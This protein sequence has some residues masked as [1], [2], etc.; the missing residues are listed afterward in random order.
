MEYFL[1]ILNTILIYT[2]LVA[3]LN[4]ILGY[5]GMVSMCHA[6]L[7]GIGGYVSALVA[8][9]F[10]VNFL[11]GMLLA[12]L[13]AGLV[14]L[15]LALPSL[16]IKDEYLILFT[17]AFQLVVWGLM[18]TEVGITRGE[19]G[20]SDV[21][22]AGMFGI[23]LTT[24]LTSFPMILLLSGILFLVC[25]RVTHSPFGRMLKCIRE[26]ELA[27]RSLGKNVLKGKVLTFMVGGMVAGGVGSIF[28]HYNAYINPVSFSL[29]ATILMIAMVIL[30][31]S[32]NMMGS[33]LGTFLLIGIPEVLRFVPGSGTWIGPFRDIVFG[34]LLIIFMRF[35]PQGLIPEY[36]DSLKKKN[37]TIKLSP[38]DKKKYLDFTQSESA[39]SADKVIEV[40]GVRKSFGGV[41]ALTYLNMYLES[42]KITGLVGPNGSGKTTAFNLISGFTP[43][44]EGEIRLNGGNITNRAPHEIT[45]LGIVRSWQ[46]VRVFRN[47]TVLDNVMVACPNQEGENLVSLFLRPNK[48]KK[49]EIKNT[50]KA[51]ALLSFVGLEER[52]YDLAA[53]LSFAEQKELALARLMATDASIFLLDEPASGIDMASI[54]FI[55]NLV[56]SLASLGKTVCLVEHNLDIVRGLAH[57]VFFIDQGVVLRDGPPE[58][59]MADKELAEIYF[60]S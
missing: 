20:L 46:D 43:P 41:Q 45:R 11:V 3:S 27:S 55:E 44:D 22:R 58:V 25:W 16:K 47:M 21:P 1:H 54:E 28:A 37:R 2:V 17:V 8:M 57:K 9:H 13:T 50:E 15:L 30:G 56:K 40:V 51:L 32:A 35:R 18:I 31:G 59:L 39:G 12:I 48:V 7:F 14:G 60:G 49:E 5:G 6:A 24:P 19:T 26:D 52:A 42:G 33:I 29:H 38:E 53:D 23:K 36:R 10:G 34:A 4:L